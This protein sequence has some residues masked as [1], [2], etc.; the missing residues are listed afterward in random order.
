MSS[1]ALP[2]FGRLAAVNILANVTVPLAGLVDIAMLGRLDDIRFL[3][4]VA[5][6]SV[7]FD[8]IYWNAGFLRMATTGAT[9]Q[10]VGRG[11]AVASVQVLHRTLAL[12]LAAGFFLILL[13]DPIGDLALEVLV[14]APDVETE[15]RAYYDARMLG[16]PATLL[17]LVFLGWYLGRAESQIALLL[18][19]VANVAN[20]VLNYVFIMRLDLAAQGAGL[21]T[22]LSQYL[23]LGVALICYRSRVQRESWSGSTLFDRPAI[24]GLLRLHRDL[25]L[26]TLCLTTVFALFTNISAAMGTVWLAANTL[27]LRVVT[28]AAFLVDGVAY[29]TESL[30]GILYGRGDESALAALLAKAKRVGLFFA[31]VVLMVVLFVPDLFFGLLTSHEPVV[32]TA[33]AFRWW[34]LPILLLGSLAY[35]Y[36]GYFLGLTAAI[37]LRNA[38]A[39][40]FGFF[41]PL[42]ALAVAWNNAHVLWA[43]LATFMAVRV[44][45]LHRASHQ[46]FAITDDGAEGSS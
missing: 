39:I 24:F 33:V 22:A 35:I 40:S 27:L 17:G 42:A 20:I 38:M 7:V 19:V 9:A 15:A 18:T 21:A 23:L 37:T 10:A 3:A 16:A 43:S 41:L 28:T 13:R 12:A 2:Q 1:A 30:T 14:G 46:H 26:R 44:G 11:D 36:D 5:L 29:A 25:L 8:Y 45:L 32:A 31:S 6:G 4:G 34:L